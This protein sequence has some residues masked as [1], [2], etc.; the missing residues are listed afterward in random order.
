MAD[1]QTPAPEAG[2]EVVQ[3][4]VTEATEAPEEVDSTEGQDESQPAEAEAGEQPDDAEDTPSK[5]KERRERRKQAQERQRLELQEAKARAAR[6]EA[7]LAQARGKTG[8]PAPKQDDYEDY[9]VYLAERAAWA[10]RRGLAEENVARLEREQEQHA[11][12]VKEVEKRR[13]AAAQENW[14]AQE[15]EARKRYADFDKV[16]KADDL[17]ISEAMASELIGKDRAAD[18]AYFLG[19]HK[20]V[21]HHLNTLEQRH[22]A[23]MAAALEALEMALPDTAPAPKTQSAAPDPVTPVK[24]RGAVQTDPTKMT[25]A[26]YRAWRAAGGTF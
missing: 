19:S 16:A 10:A 26:E 25:V 24:A 12:S 8:T 11:E 5:S 20:N 9:D 4:E 6:L 14:A 18:L 3:T 22:P 7:D 17:P 21:A 23:L 15:Q 1:D 2:D 13:M